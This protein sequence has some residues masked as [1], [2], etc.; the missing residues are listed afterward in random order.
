MT[1]A[2]DVDLRE[3]ARRE[4]DEAGFATGF[5][6]EVESELRELGRGGRGVEGSEGVRDLR[7]LLWSSI[8]NRE[9]R[10]LDQVEY[11]ERLPGGEVRLRIG[12][13]DVDSCVP[14]GSAIDRHARANTVSVYT[15]GAV[16]HMLPEQLAT[17]LTSLLEDAERLAVVTELTVAE[18]GRVIATDVYRAAV[19]NRRKLVYEPVGEWLDGRSGVPAEV[20]GVEGLEEQI[21]LQDETAER[22]RALRRTNGAL[23]LE[24]V[25]A[26]FVVVDGRAVDLVTKT[27]TRSQSIIENFMVA[28]N[29]SMAEYLEARGV[30]SLRRVVRRP[31][32]WSRMAEIAERFNE[33]LPREPDSRALS[34]FLARRRRADPAGYA[35][36]SLSVMKLVGSGEYLVEAP[37]REQEGHFGLA[38][39]DYTHSTAPNRRYPDL[40]TQRC[41]KATLAGGASPYTVSELGEIA[42]HCNRMEDAARKVERRMRKA[43]TAMLLGA[44]AGEVFEAVVTGAKPKGTF[45][46]LAAPPAEGRVVRGERGLDVGD[47][48]RV[49]L[50]STDPERGFIDFARVS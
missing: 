18:D 15:P 7:E 6:P 24:T 40:V 22:L 33:R 28:A 41:L 8:D 46:K 4:A 38:V 49:R 32:R 45:V 50:V 11:A 25:E 35:E 20:A 14:R 21:R 23:E 2:R 31:E 26:D 34:D 48:V 17:E 42:E 9:S 3:L 16:F 37:G 10:D 13:A 39:D 47:R 12:V 36:L 29:T 1:D 43:A 19:R 27:R 30:P 5:G 44:R